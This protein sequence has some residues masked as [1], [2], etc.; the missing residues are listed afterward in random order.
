M[1][2]FNE[3][4]C[5]NCA[6]RKE[7]CHSECEKYKTWSAEKIEHNRKAKAYKKIKAHWYDTKI[8]RSKK[9]KKI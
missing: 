8:K 1:M 3:S 4:P 2:N 9:G 5:H 6:D 7:N